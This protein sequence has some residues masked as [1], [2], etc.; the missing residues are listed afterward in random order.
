[1][2][3]DALAWLAR[4]QHGIGA[5]EAAAVLGVHPFDTALAVYARK[6]GLRPESEATE[7]MEA[8]QR[9]EPVVADWFRDRM[10]AQ[11]LHVEVDDPGPFTIHVHPTDTH[12][13][14]TVDRFTTMPKVKG[15]G[16]LQVKTTSAFNR[17]AWEDEPPLYVQVQVQ[18]EM[19]CTA[20]EWGMVVVLIGGQHLH[21]SAVIPRNDKFIAQLRRKLRTF[22]TRVEEG[23]MPEPTHADAAVLAQLYP[24]SN[25]EVVPLGGLEQVDSLLVDTRERIAKLKEVEADCEN[26]IKAALADNEMGVM[27]GA[28]YTYRE[29]H[30]KAHAVKASTYRRL[31]RKPTNA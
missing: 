8:G 7:Y 4:R 20:R 16:V 9:L 22:W 2:H 3:D 27:D 21:V 25:S 11:G 10:H 29:V 31:V 28:V 14:A 12:L 17:Q 15:D 30:R 24:R 19:A 5:S 13:L 6:R 18:H 23:D 1:V 26:R